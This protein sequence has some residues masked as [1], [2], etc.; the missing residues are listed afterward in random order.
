MDSGYR[1][2]PLMYISSPG[3]SPAAM[4]TG[5]VLVSLMPNSTLLEAARS[6]RRLNMGMASSNCRVA[7]EVM[8][9]E[10]DVIVAHVVQGLAANS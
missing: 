7:L 9:V 6:S 10:Y 5:K 1:L 3:S 2:L 4:V 8:V